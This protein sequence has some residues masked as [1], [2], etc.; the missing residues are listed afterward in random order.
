LDEAYFDGF[1][2][3]LDYLSVR[4]GHSWLTLEKTALAVS[5]DE[6][7]VWGLTSG[8]KVLTPRSYSDLESAQVYIFSGVGAKG[9]RVIDSILGE[10]M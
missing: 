4:F 6:V 9:I 8:E 3:V 1:H 2:C 10:D 5:S 7:E